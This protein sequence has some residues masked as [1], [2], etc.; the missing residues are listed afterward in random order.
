MRSLVILLL[1]GAPALAV[2]LTFAQ[3]DASNTVERVIVADQ[4]FINS[5]VVGNPASWHQTYVSPTAIQPHNYAGQG[6]QWHPEVPCFA[7]P[8]P[9]PRDPLWTLNMVSCLW[10]HP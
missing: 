3:V 8:V 10:V 9:D 6:Y 4:A 5:G 2:E 7:P 1:S